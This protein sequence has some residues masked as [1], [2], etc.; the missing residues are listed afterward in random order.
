M[1]RN[2]TCQF[3]RWD[4]V[5]RWVQTDWLVALYVVSGRKFSKKLVG[6][7]GVFGRPCVPVC[8]C[9]RA[10]GEHQPG[11]IHTIIKYL[12]SV[13]CSCNNRRYSGRSPADH[14]RDHRVGDMIVGVVSQVHR[15]WLLKS[16]YLQFYRE[17]TIIE[18]NIN[19]SNQNPSRNHRRDPPS[20]AGTGRGSLLQPSIERLP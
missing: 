6:A 16:A 19:Q 11:F 15:S 8:S 18:S 10:P 2:N 7:F 17:P 3:R 20:K 1:E 12:H 14:H 4:V 13:K 5:T 9:S